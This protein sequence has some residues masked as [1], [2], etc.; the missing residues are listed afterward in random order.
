MTTTARLWDL[1]AK[2]PEKTARVLSGHTGP[3][4]AVAVSGDGRWLV[5][6]SW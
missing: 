3:V 5:T 2:E 1:T 4:V 6:G